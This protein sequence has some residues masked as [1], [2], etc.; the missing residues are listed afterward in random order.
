MRA[1]RLELTRL[2]AMTRLPNGA[3]RVDA[4]PTR[5]G[6]LEYSN[7]DGKTWL[8]YRPPEEVF[9]ADSLATLKAA[10]VTDLHPEEM[11]TPAN[12]AALAKGHMG[13]DARRADGDL[14]GC[15]V[16]VQ[17]A[18]E[19][20]MVERNER[21]ELS[22]GYECDIDETPGT[23]P[24]GQ[25]YDKIQRAIRYNHVALLPA[26]EGR[27][28]PQC[29]LRLDARGAFARPPASRPKNVRADAA[30]SRAQ[31]HS[32]K[33]VIKVGK[34]SFKIDAAPPAAGDEPNPDQQ[35][36]DD[37][38]E[39]LQAA[40]G[41]LEASL[42]KALGDLAAAKAQMNAQAALNAPPPAD[43][44][45]EGDAPPDDMAMD[46]FVAK[47]D[48]KRA[49]AALVLGAKV[50]VAKIP[51]GELEAR[52]IAHV[53]P[54]VKLDALDAKARD[55]LFSAA[56]AGAKKA[57]GATAGNKAGEDGKRAD[58]ARADAALAKAQADAAEASR[59][60]GA[61]EDPAARMAKNREAQ[62]AA[63]MKGAR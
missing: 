48:A 46:A 21:V 51:T 37:G 61:D 44:S 33:H 20:G 19:V 50:D 28:G 34:R 42:T 56:V 54:N 29:A 49:D 9:A 38:P 23:T 27:A 18:A 55:E 59:T 17:D 7:A 60:D 4:F 1:Q 31:E 39:A 58:A 43:A 41:T 26:N 3:L 8:E 6:V 15:S 62:R 10:T 16:I 30:P 47:R 40:I 36:A 63:A 22:C 32:M 5:A 12:W 35:K 11:V 2:D 14:V 13:D 24:D 25:R 53:L 52:V 45:A 57:T